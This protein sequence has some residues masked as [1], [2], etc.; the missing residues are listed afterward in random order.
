MGKCRSAGYSKN[1][2]SKDVLSTHQKEACDQAIREAI[3]RRLRAAYSISQPM[4][5]R[6]VTL[7]NQLSDVQ[8]F[9]SNRAPRP[10]T[11]AAR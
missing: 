8:H 11:Q 7:L 5:D 1:M 6:L 10:T 3:G 9:R 2:A 4:P